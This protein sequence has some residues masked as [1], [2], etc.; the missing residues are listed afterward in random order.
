MIIIYKLSNKYTE[1]HRRDR[2][3]VMNSII[4]WFILPYVF[5]ELCRVQSG[6]KYHGSND[7]HHRGNRLNRSCRKKKNKSTRQ[8][9][10]PIIKKKI[11]DTH[12]HN[13][14]KPYYIIH[15]Y[16]MYIILQQK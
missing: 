3:K 11:M 5:C 9:S 14:L 10:T 7:H 4:P 13:V 6:Q 2:K 1:N 12:K 16:T 15:E 8:R